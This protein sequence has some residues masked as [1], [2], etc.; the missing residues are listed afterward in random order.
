[1]YRS[2]EDIFEFFTETEREK[3]FGKEPRTVYENIIQLDK[4][5]EKIKCL[6]RGEVFRDDLIASR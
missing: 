3:Y 2:E 4:E 6:K 1:M 5:K